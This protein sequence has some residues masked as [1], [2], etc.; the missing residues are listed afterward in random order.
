MVIPAAPVTWTARPAGAVVARWSRS[1]VTIVS[2]RPPAEP[3]F[4]FTVRSSS[5]PSELRSI[6]ASSGREA[7][8]STLSTASRSSWG[9]S[10]LVVHVATRSRYARSASVSPS[11]RENVSVAELDAAA[12]GNAFSRA[13]AAWTDGAYSGRKE[14]WSAAPAEASDGANLTDSTAAMTQ[15]MTMRYLSLYARTPIRSNIAGLHGRASTTSARGSRKGLRRA[16]A[17]S[18][19]RRRIRYVNVSNT[20]VYPGRR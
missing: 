18:T 11:S 5:T 19:I 12:P 1:C 7:A 16:G 10:A 6:D 14:A 9:A 17:A 20:T 4:R 2:A 8:E 3:T 15:T 13:S